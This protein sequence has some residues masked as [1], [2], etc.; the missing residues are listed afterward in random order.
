MMGTN[1][2]RNEK[3]GTWIHT[4]YNWAIMVRFSLLTLIHISTPRSL[5]TETLPD[6]SEKHAYGSAVCKN[7][8]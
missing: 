6:I 1:T 5:A 8:K 7:W 3:T 2:D 4:W